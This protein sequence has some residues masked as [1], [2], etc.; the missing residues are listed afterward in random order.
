MGFLTRLT[1]KSGL[2][3]LPSGSFTVDPHGNIV[4]STVPQWV[5]EAQVR[6]IGE[7]I[8]AVFKA[9]AAARLQFSEMK[10]QYEAFKITAR[11]M[12]GGAIIF[13]YPKTLQALNRT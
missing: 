4:S 3:R 5:P 12:R 6:E 7:Q 1:P 10:I 11:E 8:L 13:L 9:A 2:H